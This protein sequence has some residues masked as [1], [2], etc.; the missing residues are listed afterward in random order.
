MGSPVTW[1]RYFLTKIRV[2]FAQSIRVYISLSP[3][4]PIRFLHGIHA[5]PGC[6]ILLQFAFVVVSFRIVGSTILKLD[7]RMCH[8][9][10]F[11]N[12]FWDSNL[13]MDINFAA[14]LWVGEDQGERNI[15]SCC[16]ECSTRSSHI[17][18]AFQRCR[19]DTNFCKSGGDIT[20]PITSKA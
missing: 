20:Y 4:S 12:L 8:G 1:A 9:C 15:W 14:E 19:D 2:S 17:Q 10:F 16:Q 18:A 11:K 7:S 3:L 13:P 6:F 5:V